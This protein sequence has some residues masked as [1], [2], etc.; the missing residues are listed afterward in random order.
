M[1]IL[2]TNPISPDAIEELRKRHD[3]ICAY[4]ASKEHLQALIRDREVLIF[5]SGIFISGELLD[6]SPNLRLLIRAGSGIDNIDMDYVRRR[7]ITLERIP[8]PAAKAVAEMSF[9]L[10]LALA[11]NI[12]EA[13]RLLRQGHWAKNDLNGFLLTGKVLGIIGVGN[14]GSRVGQLGVAWGMKV[15]GCVD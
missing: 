8:E 13:D 3:V 1:N 12:I 14:I 4:N 5:R 6:C 15:I 9:A 10:M 7:C 11:R 2:I